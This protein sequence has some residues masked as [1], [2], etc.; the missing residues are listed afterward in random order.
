MNE[1]K[2]PVPN[3]WYREWFDE[4][5][6]QVYPHRDQ[7]EAEKFLNRW[8]I[9][10][11]LEPGGW[12]LDLGCGTGRYAGL[13][14]RKDFR[15][16]GIDLSRPL[17]SIARDESNY[18]DNLWYVRADMR[19]V[20]SSGRFSLIVSLFT[21]FGYFEDNEQIQLLRDVKEL[22]L[23]DGIFVLDLP[24]RT[25]VEQ[26]VLDGAVTTRNDVDMTIRETRRIDT[27]RARVIKQI[28]IR[29]GN[30]SYRY[31]E[32]VRLYHKG[33]MESLLSDTGFRI[34]EPVWG[35]YNGNPF[36]IESPRM[37]YF[38]NPHA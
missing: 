27:E 28:D 20:P 7:Q 8:Q 33:E 29:S 15:V 16:L 19:S 1:Q 11:R 13:I 25:A 36:N 5:Y 38:V 34:S 24:N 22:L 17:L 21:S 6:L 31:Y 18:P 9:W 35:D 3:D 32:S 2:Q 10:S 4:R 12:C 26:S 30:D 14:A 37:I 23:P